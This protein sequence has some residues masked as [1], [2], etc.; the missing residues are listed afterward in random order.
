MSLIEKLTPESLPE[1]VGKVLAWVAGLQPYLHDETLDEIAERTNGSKSHMRATLSQ[2]VEQR[3]RT[4][5]PRLLLASFLGV[6]DGA[7]VSDPLAP[8]GPPLIVRD[9]KLLGH[10]PVVQKTSGW[11]HPLDTYIKALIGDKPYNEFLIRPEKVESTAKALNRADSTRHI[12][13]RLLAT[14]NVEAF[15]EVLQDKKRK[16]GFYPELI[17]TLS[18][19]QRFT[20]IRSGGELVAMD[21][22]TREALKTKVLKDVLAGETDRLIVGYDAKNDKPVLGYFDRFEVWQ[23][24]PARAM[25]L[26][27]INAPGDR[28]SNGRVADVDYK[29]NMF[30]GFPEHGSGEGK[31]WDR[32]KEHMRDIL[33]CGDNDA[34]EYLLNWLAHMFQKPWEKPGVAIVT[35]G[36]KR[37]GKGTVADAIRAALGVELSAIFIDPAHFIGRF[38]SAA[39]PFLFNQI[40][41]AVFARDPRTESPLKSRITDPTAL[42][43]LKFRQ[44]Y[45]IEAF[46]RFWFNRNSPAAVPITFDEARYFVL[47][48][49]DERANDH[50][51]FAAIRQQLYHEG[52]LAAMIHELKTRDISKFNVRRPPQ[53]K[54]RTAMVIEMMKPEER[55]FVEILRSGEI[56][57]FHASGE[58][59]VDEQLSETDATWIDKSKVHTALADAFKKH[60]GKAADASEIGK[61]LHDSGLIEGE[62]NRHKQ[63]GQE[64]AYRFRPL[65]EARAEYAKRH[66]IDVEFLSGDDNAPMTPEERFF[67]WLSEGRQIVTQF[68]LPALYAAYND[69]RK[70]AVPMNRGGNVTENESRI[71]N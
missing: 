69:F 12:P 34:Y 16:K 65:P 64:A 30:A 10:Q 58:R 2:L 45:Q 26:G 35:W 52:G 29:F 38:A 67:D 17:V 70:I 53:T 24:H 18:L 43:E 48:V 21:V 50:D 57:Q 41:E 15:V 11:A 54:A 62:R 39:I 31:S 36:K 60:G 63:R 51:Y 6:A 7:E 46:E 37:T 59:V 23:S 49:S 14:A 1:E 5:Y 19:N 22:E 27:M 4:K 56:V 25:Y 40:E 42:V 61:A 8:G 28:D 20:L 3:S 32:L 71:V 13:P 47:H 44:P 33:C 68:D 9:A 55:C 66:G